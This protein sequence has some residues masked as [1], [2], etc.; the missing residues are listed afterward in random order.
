MPLSV[1][2]RIALNI[3][4]YTSTGKG[5]SPYPSYLK[6]SSINK[7]SPACKESTALKI[8]SLTSILPLSRITEITFAFA[9]G[10]IPMF[11]I[12]LSAA[13]TTPRTEVP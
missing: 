8:A 6:D 9:F 13:E 11:P 5:S 3:L 2:L 7:T 4:G 10:A 12:R 1:P